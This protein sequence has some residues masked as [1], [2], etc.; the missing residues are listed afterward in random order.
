MIQTMEELIRACEIVITT[1]AK[2]CAYKKYNVKR[3]DGEELRKIELL[4][5]NMHR[6]FL[7]EECPYG[8]V[9]IMTAVGLPI[10]KKVCPKA[11]DYQVL[12]QLSMVGVGVACLYHSHNAD[13]HV[14]KIVMFLLKCAQ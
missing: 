14:V 7:Y 10:F 2:S 9:G 11:D 5:V 3:A 1:Q 6:C 4:L 8:F 12:Q 13:S